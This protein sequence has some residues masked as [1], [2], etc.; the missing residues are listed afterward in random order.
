METTFKK[1]HWRAAG[2]IAALMAVAAL[3][4]TWPGPHLQHNA[5]VESQFDG[6]QIYSQ[7]QYYTAGTL[8]DP[9]AIL[10]LKPGYTLESS[11]WQA[12]RMTPGELEQWISA[13]KNSDF[14]DYNQFPN[15]ADLI[16]QNG[17]VAG[18]Y[19]SVWR[20]PLVR[21]PADKTIALNVPIGEYRMT[22]KWYIEG[23]AGGPG[24]GGH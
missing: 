20:Y 17:E 1:V 6:Y 19:Y 13:M 16:G 23:F 11:E 12:V 4:C 9:R 10:A 14:V 22:N 3:G 24:K 5:A 18:H 21:T 8:E 2:I 15:G 7:Y